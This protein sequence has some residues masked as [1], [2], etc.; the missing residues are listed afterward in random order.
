VQSLRWGNS[1]FRFGPPVCGRVPFPSTVTVWGGGT[2]RAINWRW[3]TGFPCVPLHF[4]H[5]RF[6]NGCCLF[7]TEDSPLGVA[8][9]IQHLILFFYD[10]RCYRSKPGLSARAVSEVQDDARAPW[11]H[12]RSPRWPARRSVL[13]LTRIHWN[14][15]RRHRYG[16]SRSVILLL[17]A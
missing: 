2:L 12:G 8:T 16:H 13:H 1:T 5:W 11:W 15:Q 6:G 3:G 9:V 7:R 14:P 4:N 10:D 17:R